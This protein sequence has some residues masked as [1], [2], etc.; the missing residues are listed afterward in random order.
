M[1]PHYLDW[2]NKP[3]P[4]K[5]YQN[6]SDSIIPLPRDFP[7][8]TADSLTAIRGAHV[9]S[10]DNNNEKVKGGRKMINLGTVAELLFFSAG[11]TRKMITAG[12]SVY[13]M[14]AASATG[15]LYPIELYVVCGKA[16]IQGLPAGVYHFNPLE[17]ALVK[18]REGD[19]RYLLAAA[20]GHDSGCLAAPISIIFTSLAWRNAW[21]YQARSYRHWFWD[22]GVIAANL[23]AVCT[24]EELACRVLLGFVDSKIDKLLGLKKY[25][26]ATIAI[27]PIGIGSSVDAPKK[28]TDDPAEMATNDEKALTEYESL[29]GAEAEYPS[30]WEANDASSLDGVD[31][32][33]RWRR[34]VLHELPEQR[35]GTETNRLKK[36]GDLAQTLKNGSSSYSSSS[37]VTSIS[38]TDT[39]LRRGSTRRFAREAITLEQLSTVIDAST[40]DIPLD[41]LPRADE[42][43]VEVYLIANQVHQLPSG[44]Y[45]F[46]KASGSLEQLKIGDFRGVS[47]YLCLEQ[48]LFRDA[49]AVLFL[50]ADLNRITS[51]TAL[52]NRGYRAAQFEA[53]VRAGKIYLS[54]YSLKI[55]ASGT[56]FYDDAVSEFFL[57]NAKGKSAMIAVGLGVPAYRARTGTILPQFQ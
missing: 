57:P 5:V 11:L 41:F 52:G 18:L 46:D 35:A 33:E 40:Q 38:L 43:L 25:K 19:Q 30:I 53:A 16:Q 42:T 32:V 12:S 13:Y 49:S 20:C 1:S 31:Q 36:L 47:S 15:A 2:E 48:A 6:A 10:L 34:G 26:E 22:S 50:M 39:I 45:H 21:K 17:F 4:F 24:S 7:H 56:T 23:L 3:S 14:R 29:S 37:P 51:S 55:G 8:P 27:A 44:S 54:S 9:S 28:K